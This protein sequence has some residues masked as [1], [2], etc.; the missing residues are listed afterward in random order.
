MCVDRNGDGKYGIYVANYGGPTRFYEL[1]NG[2][3]VDQ[4]PLLN[5]NRITGGRAV[6]SGHILSN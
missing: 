6:V 4:A 1:T 2:N 5:I 3:I